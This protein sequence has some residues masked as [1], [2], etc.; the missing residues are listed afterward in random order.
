[1]ISATL[2]LFF[3]VVLRELPVSESG[4]EAKVASRVDADSA[5][6][7]RS[8]GCAWRRV[9]GDRVVVGVGCDSAGGRMG[10]TMRRSRTAPWVGRWCSGRDGAGTGG[11]AGCSLEYVMQ[12]GHQVSR[13]E[14]TGPGEVQIKIP[15]Q[16]ATT[17]LDKS[18]T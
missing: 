16:A 15:N 9:V 7:A 8:C 12:S 14:I 18:D 3:C 10:A 6:A 1:M 17:E 2:I 13:I 11:G 5:A 4:E